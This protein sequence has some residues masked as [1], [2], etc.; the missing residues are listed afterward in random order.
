MIQLLDRIRIMRID[1]AEANQLFGM[2]ADVV[3]DVFVRHQHADMTRAEA[4]DDGA[5]DRLHRAPVLVEIDR[6]VVVGRLP[7]ADPARRAM[8]AS[9]RLRGPLPDVRVYVDNH[10]ERQDHCR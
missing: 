1:R 4:E 10:A 5:I 8:N 6:D 9:L 7:A 3:R 2:T